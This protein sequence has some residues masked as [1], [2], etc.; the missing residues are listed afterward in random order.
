MCKITHLRHEALLS[1]QQCVV[2]QHCRY[3]D[4]QTKG[5]H[6]QRLAN[7]AGDLIQT[8]LPRLSDAQQ[9]VVNPPNRPEQ[10]DKGRSTTDG[11]KYRLSRA[12]VRRR[13]FQCVAQT[14]FEP[15][16]QAEYAMQ[17]ILTAVVVFHRLQA[18]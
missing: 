18:L 17:I 4:G 9:S 7:G 3:R 5:G 13:I 11:G 1:A 12:Q 6:N 15:V 2:A 10:A 8:D 16:A 14:A